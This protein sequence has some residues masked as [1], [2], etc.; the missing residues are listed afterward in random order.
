M[1][2]Q[3]IPGR[4]G[5]NGDG[6]WDRDPP[7]LRAMWAWAAKGIQLG[8]VTRLPLIQFGAGIRP[9]FHIQLK[10]LSFLGST[11]VGCNKEEIRPHVSTIGR[12]SGQFLTSIAAYLSGP[13]DR[14]QSG[15]LAYQSRPFTWTVL[16]P[17]GDPS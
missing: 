1:W 14:L 9:A 6:L 15:S 17:H 2:T 13:G 16:V 12:L 11:F 8:Q 4:S 7:G 3:G 5:V 10:A